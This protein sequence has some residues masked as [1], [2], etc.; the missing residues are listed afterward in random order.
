MTETLKGIRGSVDDGSS[1]RARYP[2]PW[3]MEALFVD[4]V[5]GSTD[6]RFRRGGG[7][8]LS[9]SARGVRFG[10]SPGILVWPPRS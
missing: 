1:A 8:C 7:E 2:K 3:S 4:V 5:A 10:V 9:L 6:P